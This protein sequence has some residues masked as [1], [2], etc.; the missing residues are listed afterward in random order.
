[1]ET[2]RELM[3]DWIDSLTD[4]KFN[5]FGNFIDKVLRGNKR[6]V[7]EFAELDGNI[8]TAIPIGILDNATESS[9]DIKPIEFVMQYTEE[10]RFGVLRNPYAQALRKLITVFYK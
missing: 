10:N 3:K 6:D 9:Q 8:D 4:E 7:C 2:D 1:M 5:T